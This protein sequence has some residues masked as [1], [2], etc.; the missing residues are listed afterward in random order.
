MGFYLIDVPSRGASGRVKPIFVGANR[1]LTKVEIQGLRDGTIDK[2]GLPCSGGKCW[3]NADRLDFTPSFPVWSSKREAKPDVGQTLSFQSVERLDFR[4]EK[5]S[6]ATSSAASFPFRT[7]S[8]RR[9]F[10]ASETSRWKLRIAQSYA[11]VPEV[12]WSARRPTPI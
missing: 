4:S 3:H 7:P 12:G 1:F 9:S 5:R 11:S 2:V 8:R 10:L 6:S